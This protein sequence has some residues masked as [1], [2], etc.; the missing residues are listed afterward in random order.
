MNLLVLNPKSGNAEDEE[1]WW[2]YLCRTGVVV[3]PANVADTLAL[4][5][6]TASDCTSMFPMPQGTP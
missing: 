5:E 1:F 6:L 3:E 4:P 2:T